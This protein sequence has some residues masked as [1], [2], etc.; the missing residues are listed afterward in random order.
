VYIGK[1]HTPI[2]LPRRH[3][4]IEA[5]TLVHFAQVDNLNTGIFT[6][7]VRRAC[8]TIGIE[9][10]GLRAIKAHVHHQ[11]GLSGA[12]TTAADILDGAYISVITA[13]VVGLGDAT[14]F[15]VTIIVRT[16][17][18]VIAGLPPRAY[19]YSSAVT[20]FVYATGVPVVTGS[21]FRFCHRD[22]ALS[23]HA[24][25]RAGTLGHNA[26]YRVPAHATSEKTE[27]IG[28]AIIA[29]ITL[30]LQQRF[31][32]H[33]AFD[34]KIFGARVFIVQIHG[35]SRSTNSLHTMVSYSTVVFT[36]A[37]CCSVLGSCL[38][39]ALNPGIA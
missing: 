17:V 1:A 5:F 3:T 10:I 28:R 15:R 12:D 2:G 6:G 27:V 38:F 33:D 9:A 7:W 32:L 21:A 20:I 13:K 19:T 29:V 35:R 16:G 25:R 14:N 4:A 39:T 8:A 22:A 37:A 11:I 18:E 23:R 36:E 30:P 34:A 31:M 24:R 26:L